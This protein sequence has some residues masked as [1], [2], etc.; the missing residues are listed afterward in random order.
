MVAIP[1]LANCNY[2]P[3]KAIQAYMKLRNKRVKSKITLP[4]FMT[5]NLGVSGKSKP[6]KTSPGFY[7]NSRFRKDVN[8]AVEELV[9]HHPR[10]AE[11]CRW[12]VLH[13]LRSGVLT[14]M[15]KFKQIPPEIELQS[16]FPSIFYN[17]QH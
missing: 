14:E 1:A 7:T 17:A 4:L 13:S 10:M 2:C 12:L 6:D 9:K 16:K 3:V 8:T 15:Q 11:V 5:E